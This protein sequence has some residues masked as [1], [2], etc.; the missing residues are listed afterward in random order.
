ME[1]FNNKNNDLLKFKINSEGIDTKKIEARLILMTKENDNYV[2]FGNIKDNTCVF[3]I[4]E[5][6]L[7]ENN[8]NGDIKFEIISG[9]MYFNVWSD[10]F[11]VKSKVK[12]TLENIEEKVNEVIKPTIS[13]STSNG[14]EIIKEEKEE[15]KEEINETKE[16]KENIKDEEIKNFSSFL[17]KK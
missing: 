2:F 15:E 1:F 13:I 12:I 9:D 6:T 11:K 4:P 14:P 5:L 3:D 17:D 7:Y 8:M 10:K 16:E